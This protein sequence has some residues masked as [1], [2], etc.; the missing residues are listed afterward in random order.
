[1][2]RVTPSVSRRLILT[3]GL[4]A[5]GLAASTR[6][7]PPANDRR[8][9]DFAFGG[10][11]I[12]RPLYIAISDTHAAQ[13]A[14]LIPEIEA[15]ISRRL[16]IDALSADDLYAAYTIDLLQQ[17]GRYDIVSLRDAWIP[18]FGRQAYF[19]DL[20]DV[21]SSTSSLYPAIVASAATGIDGSPFVAWPWTID[22]TIAMW[23]SA[24][25]QSVDF[26]SWSDFF[27]SNPDTGEIPT[28]VDLTTKESAAEAFRCTILSFGEDLVIPVS[29]APN[30]DSY[31]ASRALNIVLRLAKRAALIPAAGSTAVDFPTVVSLFTG[32]ASTH[33]LWP[34]SD[35][36]SARIPP[37]IM[38]TGQTDLGVWMFGVPAGAPDV[39]AARDFVELLISNT[40]QASLWPQTGL[41]PA[42]RAQLDGEWAPDAAA[43]EVT[44]GQT[45]GTAALWPRIRS[46]RTLMQI[47][48]QMVLDAIAGLDDNASLLARANA[49]MLAELTQENEL[50]T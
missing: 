50:R 21:S 46:F 9:P 42:I 16:E 13:L 33:S 12:L 31:A 28:F 4:A 23:R 36:R 6:I 15:T 1:M 5:F 27:L 10:N 44:I 49:D 3:G 25:G 19:A 7:H 47:A 39:D 26:A 48:G 20:P 43:L 2:S 41:I 29:N 45:L 17:T 14:P 24:T 18:Y 22:A 40:I 34:A 11:A 32:A 30:L 37:N 35:W 8:T 38:A